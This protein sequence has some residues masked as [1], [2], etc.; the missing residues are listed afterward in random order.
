MLQRNLKAMAKAHSYD[1]QLE[2]AKS[3]RLAKQARLQQ[4]TTLG[5]NRDKTGTYYNAVGTAP[6]IY[7]M[8]EIPENIVK[9]MKANFI[10][11]QKLAN[12]AHV[13]SDESKKAAEEAKRRLDKFTND[14]AKLKKQAQLKQASLKPKPEFRFPIPGKKKN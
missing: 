3:A 13:V 12:Q 8:K 2:S 4:A 11:K 6:T 7:D 5:T 10:K 9:S 14:L 1:T